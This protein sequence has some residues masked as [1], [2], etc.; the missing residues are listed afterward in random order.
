MII[1]IFTLLIIVSI[2]GLG[3]M[4]IDYHRREK[5]FGLLKL[6]D[7]IE[8]TNRDTEEISNVE[9]SLLRSNKIVYLSSKIDKNIALKLLI[10]TGAYLAFLVSAFLWHFSL[11]KE[12]LI[13]TFII[14]LCLV[15]LI[16]DRIKKSVVNSKIKKISEDM[17]FIIDTMAVC[18]QSGMTI[19]N[20]LKYIAE[21]TQQINPEIA[22]LFDRIVKKTNINGVH[23]ALNE[24]T[25][26]VPSA[27][28]NMFCSALQQSVNYGTSLY[29]VLIT[30]SQE[31]REMQLLKVEE[32]VSSLSAKMTLPMMFFIMF[33]LLV[34]VAGP[35]FIGMSQVWSQ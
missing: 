13:L 2:A 29:N 35:G 30:L 1:Y 33:P 18:V 9:R 14:L 5:A 11:S 6:D 12:F 19:E 7:L 20:A 27:E 25:N 15:I 16:P 4:L 8:R 22:M 23:D 32:K 28:V 3:V 10:V 17:P 21:N 34:I 26:D 31:M 24:L